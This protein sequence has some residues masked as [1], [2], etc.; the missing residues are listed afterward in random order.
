MLPWFVPRWPVRRQAMKRVLGMSLPVFLVLMI[1]P[2]PALAWG[3]L[4]PILT[5]PCAIPPLGRDLGAFPGH[6]SV[7]YDRP[8]PVW[9]GWGAPPY[10][11]PPMPFV[12]PPP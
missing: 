8:W 3:W 7:P 9:Y 6:P 11:T 12:A 10:G 2:Q 1:L 5:C 4:R